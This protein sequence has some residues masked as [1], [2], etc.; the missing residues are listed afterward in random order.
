MTRHYRV[1][2]GTALVLFALAAVW[3][4][5]SSRA[6]RPGHP[7]PA[8]MPS[9]AAREPGHVQEGAE[10]GAVFGAAPARAGTRQTSA[11]GIAAAL[12]PDDAPVDHG[13]A[14][15]DAAARAGDAQA[16]CRIGNELMRC[17]KLRYWETREWSEEFV[18]RAA[19]Q[20]GIDRL[21]SEV[22][23]AIERGERLVESCARV[24]ARLRRDLPRYHLVAAL[25]GNVHSAAQFV[26]MATQPGDLV[27]DPQL[28]AM[29]RLHAW[30]LFR[31]AFEAGHPDVLLDWRSA[32]S[33]A[34][35]L[36]GVIPE[37]WRKPEV[38][39][40]LFRR[41][42]LGGED[43][44]EVHGRP[45]SPE[46]VDELD[47]IYRRHFEHSPWEAQFPQL[48]G[49]PDDLGERLLQEISEPLRL[50]SCAASTAP[51]SP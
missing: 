19:G 42:Y 4:V 49:R 27:R 11:S 46:Q 13:I 5:S 33:G 30:R 44:R 50:K 6:A 22:T 35:A 12:L 29:Y 51:H 48:A 24:D 31:L 3:Q 26:S 34:N 47:S 2:L 37:D 40:A 36:G 9:V 32:S 25:Q 41:V 14:Q 39:S 1:L 18:R 20:E 21:L 23:Q 15:L 7:H 8:A 28:Y 17:E 45:L 10:A 38:A 43:W 16:A